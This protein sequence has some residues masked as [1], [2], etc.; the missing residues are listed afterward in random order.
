M[1]YRIF[2]E[3]RGWAKEQGK[4]FGMNSFVNDLFDGGKRVQP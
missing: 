2:E 3:F 1:N 4:P